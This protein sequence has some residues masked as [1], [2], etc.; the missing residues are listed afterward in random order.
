MAT[1]NSAKS[2]L[3][4]TIAALVPTASAKD[5]IFLAKSLKESTQ[6]YGL[7]WNGEYT[8]GT[9]YQKDDLLSFEKSTYVCIEDN[10]V[11]GDVFDTT[12]FDLVARAG[13]DS[14]YVGL[15]NPEESLLT[16]EAGD[17]LVWGEVK[18]VD[19]VAADP[20]ITEARR[21][22]KMVFST[23]S[24]QLYMSVFEDTTG[25]DLNEYLELSTGRLIAK[26]M[27]AEYLVA[28]DHTFTV[29][30]GITTVSAV[31]VGS[32]AN[33][34]N[35]WA[36]GCGGGGALAWSSDIPVTPGEVI[37]L[38]VGAVSTATTG[39]IAANGDQSWFKSATT[40]QAD[41]GIYHSS[42]YNTFIGEGGGIGGRA[43]SYSHGGGGAGGYSGPGGEI[44]NATPAGGGGGNGDYYSS[45]YGVSAGGGTGLLGEGKSGARSCVFW[46]KDHPAAYDPDTSVGEVRAYAAGLGGEGGSGG[47]H[48]MHGENS[49]SSGGYTFATTGMAIFGGFPGGGGGG[50]GSSSAGGY[51][52][53]FGGGGAVR[54]V[55]GEGRKYPLPE[56]V[57]TIGGL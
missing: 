40:L 44:G 31:V 28:G 8:V 35:Y 33:G 34:R 41:G 21:I 16:N 53:G 55:W 42:T 2:Q 43:Y 29:P 1:V 13:I 10:T 11:A 12:K 22:G 15:G 5:M 4:D 14:E 57:V 17:G 48:G 19:V 20:K 6:L 7:N 46:G 27:Q 56:N 3:I 32:G 45:T 39:T 47:G 30:E 9:T 24:N 23:A 38:H 52:G 18:A 50:P 37:N 54:I 36:E 26:P 51:G 25:G 49:T